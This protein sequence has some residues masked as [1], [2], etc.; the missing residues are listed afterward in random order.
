MPRIK[1]MGRRND[2]VWSQMLAAGMLIVTDGD[3]LEVVAVEVVAEVDFRGDPVE[4]VDCTLASID[5]ST[6]DRTYPL[7]HLVPTVPRTVQD[8]ERVAA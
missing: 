2:L 8:S 7:D 1:M 5:G 3:C 6:F 4:R